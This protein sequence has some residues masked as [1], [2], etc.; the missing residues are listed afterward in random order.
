MADNDSNTPTAVVQGAI[1]PPTFIGTLKLQPLT[2]GTFLFLVSIKSPILNKEAVGKADY[3]DLFRAVFA[4][5][6]P[7]EECAAL[8]AQGP[9]FYDANVMGFANQVGITEL[10]E[11]G[12]KLMAHVQKA[13]DAA[14]KTKQPGDGGPSPLPPSA[15]VAA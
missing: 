4:L 1:A 11:L 2:L 10:P 12:E 13:F 9:V 3:M 8:W 7:L 14:A 5:A 15:P 6:K